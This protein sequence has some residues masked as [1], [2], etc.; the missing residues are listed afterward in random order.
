[1]FKGIVSIS[2]YTIT[3]ILYIGWLDLYNIRPAHFICLTLVYRKSLLIW[4]GNDFALF[5][6]FFT[7]S[8]FSKFD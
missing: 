5:F 4:K 1:M 2:T 3:L 8:M 7:Y 6:F